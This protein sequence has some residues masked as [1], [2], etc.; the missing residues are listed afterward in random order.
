M[1]TILLAMFL[2]FSA[3]ATPDHGV[4]KNI[5]HTVVIEASVDRQEWNLVG[6]GVAINDRKLGEG[7]LTVNHV[8]EQSRTLYLRACDFYKTECVNLIDYINDEVEDNWT[9]DWSIFKMELPKSF[10][11]APIRFKPVK[12]GEVLV[13]V[14]FSF[15][16]PWVS[17]GN[18]SHVYSNM[19]MANM[20]VAPGSSGGGVYDVNGRLIGIVVG[21]RTQYDRIVGAI[22]ATYWQAIILPTQN[23]LE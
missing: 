19:I 20:N 7:I 9:S 23:L 18:V 15:A 2:M 16:D 8:A 13:H 3:Q 14:G 4:E 12:A 22:T 21:H 11:P 5:E 6:T 17:I 1:G 10:S